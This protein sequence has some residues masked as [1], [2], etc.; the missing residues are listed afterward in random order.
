MTRHLILSACMLL[1]SAFAA[2]AQP[3]LSLLAAGDLKEPFGGDFDKDGNHVIAEYKGHCIK[4]VTMDG[5]VTLLAGDGTVG[6]A[7]GPADKAKF[8]QPHNCVV[9]P[10]T[11]IIYVA[12]TFSH[13]VREFDPKAK[14]VKTILG[15]GTKGYSGD[16]GPGDKAQVNEAY[17][18]ALDPTGKL[19]YLADIKNF[20]IRELNLETGIVTTAVGNGKKGVPADGTP[21][22][23]APLV[24]P[25]AVVVDAKG[26]IYILE[27]GGH[28]LRIVEDGK[29]KTI[30]GTG[31]QGNTGDGGPALQATMNGP[32][33]LWVEANG[34][35]I[36]ADTENHVIRKYD[37]ATGKIDR[38]AGTGKKAKG[39]P[40]GDPLQ[41]G[42]ARPHGVAVTKDGAVLVNDT[43]NN[44]ILRIK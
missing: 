6:Y 2:Q 31:K 41:C 19:L 32:K 26:R 25:R 27:R 22:K 34:N 20:R 5:K 11:G 44:R 21:A 36:I 12:D 18:V 7:D 15:T 42:L 35:V 24:D 10:K 14:T 28:A 29:I 33:F 3:K 4:S 1:T 23:D 9:H 40:T 8:N 43:E 17:H 37:A 38:I 39:E 30:V 16:G 13:T